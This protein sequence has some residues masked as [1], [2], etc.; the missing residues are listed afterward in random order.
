MKTRLTLRP[1]QNGTKKLV[2]KYGRRLVAVRYRY[3]PAYR[4]RLKTVELIEEELPWEPVTRGL[5]PS[6]LVLLRLRYHEDK[7]RQSVKAAGGMWLAERKL[8]QLNYRLVMAMGLSDRIV[9]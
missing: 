7:L 8:W 3:D 1:G 5:A 2:A 6:D 4:M 9:G